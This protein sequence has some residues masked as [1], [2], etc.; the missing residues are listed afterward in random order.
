MYKIKH[1]IHFRIKTNKKH[2]NNYLATE[3][4]YL[5]AAFRND[6]TQIQKPL[7]RRRRD[8]RFDGF[9]LKNRKNE[10]VFHRV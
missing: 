5:C 3:K 8:V 1:F 4:S 7:E 6:L 9:I 10:G 2:A